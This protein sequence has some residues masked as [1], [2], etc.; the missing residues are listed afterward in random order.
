MLTGRVELA[1]MGV[2]VALAL[3]TTASLLIKGSPNTAVDGEYRIAEELFDGTASLE[4]PLEGI[5]VS[6]T[7]HLISG[8]IVLMRG[9]SEIFSD[10]EDEVVR[11][12]S[13]NA[14]AIVISTYKSDGKSLLVIAY[15]LSPITFSQE[16]IQPQ[17][18][19]K[20]IVRYV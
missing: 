17:R 16:V 6:Q 19:L 2:L 5:L 12:Q 10:V 20:L 8:N 1:Q 3:S 4:G 9:H 15:P 7:S 11:L 13:L 18:R 14:S